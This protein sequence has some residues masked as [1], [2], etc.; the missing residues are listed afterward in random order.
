MGGA[1]AGSASCR[2]PAARGEDLVERGGYLSPLDFRLILGLWRSF[3]R[4]EGGDVVKASVAS[5]LTRALG[6][7]AR[8]QEANHEQREQQ[9]QEL[10][11]E[12]Q[13]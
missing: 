6:E 5:E 1:G 11:E 10:Q 8:G 7:R 12:G 9:E 4:V 13:R 3:S 2:A